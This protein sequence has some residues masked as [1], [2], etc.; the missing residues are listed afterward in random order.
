MPVSAKDDRLLVRDPFRYYR[1]SFSIAEFRWG[2][3]VPIGLIALIAWVK[4]MGGNPDPDLYAAAPLA[5]GKAPP[6]EAT[7]GPAPKGLAAPGWQLGQALAFARENLYVKI[8]GRADFFFSYGFQK[9]YFLP[10]QRLDAEDSVDIEL[11]DL[12]T[13]ANALGAF[14][15]ERGANDT[16]QSD[17]T[18][19]TFEARNALYMA[20]GQ[21]YVRAIGSSDN[22]HVKAQLGHL[23]GRFKDL[24]TTQAQPWAIELF[25]TGLG[26]EPG[27]VAYVPE[28]AFSFGFARDM[29]TAR[30]NG[31]AEWYVSVLSSDA[32]AGKLAQQ[33]I[34]GFAGYGTIV[35][36]TQWVKDKYLSRM[37]TAITDERWVLGVR[38]APDLAAGKAS[39]AQLQKALRSL[40]PAIRAA[41]QPAAPL[42]QSEAEAEQTELP[43]EPTSAPMEEIDER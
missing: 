23:R 38:S 17:A 30:T 26:F 40:P 20:R 34:S 29:W 3:S 8:N 14:S 13:P 7:T 5:G 21:Y 36:G 10:L 12:G 35:S 41:A 25:V 16:P 39:L 18:G 32:A 11:Y 42:P 6:S 2:L 33:L 43:N 4:W 24:G 19:M 9:L 1:R 37:S 27:K 15:G 31:D 22:E 28:N